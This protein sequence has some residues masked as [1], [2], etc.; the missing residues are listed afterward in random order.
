MSYQLDIASAVPPHTDFDVFPFM[1]RLKLEADG[2]PPSPLLQR[3]HDALLA[4]F[5]DSPWIKEY[6]GDHGRLTL[7]QRAHDIVPH[8][9]HLAAE[10]GLT[11]V[12]KKLA[13]VHRPP[14]YQVV[15]TGAADGV[16]PAAAA[17]DLATLMK[18]PIGLM[19]SILARGRQPVVK[20]GLTRAAADQYVAVLRERAG[21]DA[22]LMLEPGSVDRPPS[23]PV[24]VLEE[25]AAPTAR[26][27]APLQRAAPVAT[28][29]LTP[30]LLLLCAIA[31]VLGT[32]L[33]VTR[34]GKKSERPTIAE[35]PCAYVGQWIY[36]QERS[37]FVFDMR[38]DADGQYTAY[39]PGEKP[40]ATAGV[41]RIKD[42]TLQLKDDSGGPA[43]I[44]AI[45]P[46][47]DGKSFVL[48]IGS[49]GSELPFHLVQRLPATR[50]NY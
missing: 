11:V 4:R 48:T 28:S 22:V 23:A 5:P 27:A 30:R 44:N 35:L 15:L 25:A 1:N 8:I 16:D 47:P 49:V 37:S 3:F 18:Q 24:E 38:L 17:V 36:K 14:V 45:A 19:E 46:G 43:E 31:L 26:P 7:M 2:Q 10:L 34:M 33:V 6:A 21:C 12:D 13:E 20:K 32:N 9:L 41:W 42:G 40:K 50:C 39:L 29:W